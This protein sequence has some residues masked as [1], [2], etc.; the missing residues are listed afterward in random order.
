MSKK[1]KITKDAQNRKKVT[2]IRK[3]VEWEKSTQIKDDKY[4]A[5]WTR[6][7]EIAFS[8]LIDL[9]YWSYVVGGL[10]DKIA[11]ST[12]SGFVSDND[13][14]LWKLNKIDQTFLYRN[15]I[16]AW[17]SFFEVIRNK[18]LEVIR[19]VPFLNDWMERMDDMDGY[20]QR[21]WTQ[22]VF[23][24]QFTSQE[25]RPAKI[26]Q[27]E[28]SGA[29]SIEL[30]NTGDGCWFNPNINELYHFKNTSLKTKYF[31][32]SFFR[33]VIDQVLLLE[34][35][36]QYYTNAFDNGMIKNKIIFSKSEDWFSDDDYEKI[37]SFIEDKVNGIDKAFGSVVMDEEVGQMDLEHDIDA[38]AFIKYR[39]V[40]LKAVAL[41]LN[42]PFDIVDSLNSNRSASQVSLEVFNKDTVVPFQDEILQ[43]LKI[44]YS[45]DYSQDIDDLKFVSVD[46]KDDKEQME[47]TTGYVK[48]GIMTPNEARDKIWLSTIEGGDELKSNNNPFSDI[49]EKKEASIFIKKI[50]E[51]END[52][53]KNL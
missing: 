44:I 8:T 27:W 22:K 38:N 35:I 25:D 45:D 14:L 23:Y 28:K 33:S 6:V 9:Y 52:I 1:K 41:A 39:E 16:N 24:N 34:K 53:K 40:L 43:D 32:E 2:V 49:L 5:T 51:V 12:A 47:V 4:T 3:Q 36:D 50:N 11:K 30:R 42:I 19:L 29:S 48:N 10:T 21:L 46:T 15:R 31:G 7:P 13:D 26:K 17:N 37:T 20:V 18:K